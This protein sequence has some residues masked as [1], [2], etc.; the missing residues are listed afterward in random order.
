MNKVF[1]WGN[2][3]K[4]SRLCDIGGGKGHVAL[5]ILK[6]FPGLRAVV[7]DLPGVIADAKEVC[8]DC[9]FHRHASLMPSGS[10]GKAKC[11]KLS[12]VISWI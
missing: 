8:S 2:L 5:G 3:P 7:Q 12:R 4:G 10:F 1:P 6:T 9:V 11:L